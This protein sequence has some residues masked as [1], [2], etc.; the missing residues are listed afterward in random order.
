VAGPALPTASQPSFIGPS[1]VS[2][3]DGIVEQRPARILFQPF[4]FIAESWNGI[5]EHLRLLAKHLDRERYDLLV[6][7]HESDGPQTRQ[8]AERAALRLIPAPYR[9][10]AG[11]LGRLRALRRLYATEGIDI[12]HLHSPAAGGQT[13]AAL[14]ALLAGCAAI[15]TYHQVQP[16]RAPMRT[17]LLNRLVHSFVVNTTLAVS[18][19]V[20]ATLAAQ[21][22]VPAS[23]VLVLHNGID[24]SEAPGHPAGAPPRSDGEV[25][26][27]YFGRLSAEKGLS[28]LLGALA[29]LAE[30]C[31][32]VRTWIVGEGPQRAELEALAAQLG[33][34]DRVQ[35][36]GFRPDARAL[37]NEVDLVVH[38]PAYEGF[39]LVVLE[40]MAAGR[41]VVVN[42]SPGGLTDIVVP[43]ETGLVVPA[44]DI[45][46]L[47][48]ALALLVADPAERERLGR[49][50]RIRCEREFSARS[51]AERTAGLYEDV[52]SRRGGQ[53]A[54]PR[55]S[56]R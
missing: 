51:M 24:T 21:T 13:I 6:L 18:S 48:D 54:A 31:P 45:A 10:G 46:A 12:V 15:A 30:R 7:E 14:A 26:L 25:R 23:R 19:G 44:G 52:L 5:D 22:G 28:T 37:M 9:P 39:G 17:R 41:P 38:V 16:W 34:A 4:H 36:L 2:G 55:I 42:D 43:S 1:T 3:H 49:N 11:A 56:L 29:P 50:G 40:A 32:Q 35:F 20:R 47:V 8:L 33:V 53:P 27:A